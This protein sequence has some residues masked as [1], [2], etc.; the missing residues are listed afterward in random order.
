MRSWGRRLIPSSGTIVGLLLTAVVWQLFVLDP[1]PLQRLESLTSDLRFRVRG[2]RLPGSEVVIAAIDEKSI[3]QLGRWPW[4]YTVQARLVDRLTEYGAAVIGYDVVFSSSDTNVSIDNLR[5][6]RKKLAQSL[7]PSAGLR[8]PAK[9]RPE[10]DSAA[11]GPAPA[12]ES[13]LLLEHAIVDAN[14]DRI[15]ADALK[16]S[17]RTVLGYFFHWDER[18]IIHLSPEN[19]REFWENIRGSEH[20]DVI[21]PRGMKLQDLPLREAKAVESNIAILSKAVCKDD[22]CR[23]GFFNSYPDPQDGVIR[24]YPLIVRTPELQAQG[25]IGGVKPNRRYRAPVYPPLAIRVLEQYLQGPPA[26]VK[27][28]PEGVES[29]LLL[30]REGNKYEIPTDRQGLMLINYLGPS[31]IQAS[32][33]R[34][35]ALS[36]NRRFRFPRY[37]VVDI[38]DGRRDVAPPEAFR[39]KMVFIGATALALADDRVTPVDPSFPGVETHATV[40]DNILRRRFLAEPVWSSWYTTGSIF[41][42]GIFLAFLLP[43]L[44]AMWSGTSATLLLIGGIALNYFLFVA[45]GWWLSVVYPGLATVVVAGGMTLYRYVGEE[46]DKRFIR[47]TFETYLAP[48]LIDRMVQTRTPPQLGGSSGLRTAYFTDIASFSSFS[49]VLSATRLV[50]L[51]NE[52]LTAMTDILLAEGGTLDKYE[53]DAIVAFFGAPVPLEDHAARALRTALG[54]QQALG[55]LRDKWTSEGAKWPDLVHHMRMRIGIS[56]GEIV[57]GNMGSTMRMNYTMMG[58]VVN[59]AARL[60]AAAKQYGIYIQCTTDTL[61]LAGLDDFEWRRIDKVRVVGKTEA[62]ETVEIMAYQ[63]QLPEEQVQM[64]ALYHQGLE[65]YRQQKWSE[66]QAK[67]AESDKLEDMFPKRPTNPSRVYLERCDFFAANPPGEDWDGSWTLTSK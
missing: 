51:L 29:V 48:E 54:M 7:V 38:I 59:T 55:R 64:R 4:P 62:L 16:R 27:G 61:T 63:G 65:L 30:D 15:F 12:S 33:R 8:S 18:D 34:Q 42:I 2:P 58:D 66:A 37:A 57:T 14:H 3:D 60:E 44:R 56:S 43:R 19:R 11:S 22:E 26:R 35:G 39:G 23:S 9:P 45:Y 24:R 31:E 46:K 36:P 32:E 17:G 5:E 20:L 1:I 21:L 6:L 50:D 13:E 49:E 47:K 41:L 53:G 40:I 52:Y 10:A 28:D 25:Q 67:F